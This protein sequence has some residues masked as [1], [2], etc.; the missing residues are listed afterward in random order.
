MATFTWTT[1]ESGFHCSLNDPPTTIVD[2]IR[3]LIGD[4][5][6]IPVAYLSDAQILSI[7]N[8]H[9]SDLYTSAA[10]C[11][12]A[13]AA[14]AFQL[15]QEVQQGTRFRLKNFDLDK[16]YENFLKLATMLRNKSTIGG[17]PQYGAIGGPMIPETLPCPIPGSIRPWG[18]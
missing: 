4:K 9:D 10:E 16:A 7:A 15:Y 3:I 11:A 14:I 8:M 18:Y 17:L 5:N 1:D 6:G 2:Q 12:E 13:C